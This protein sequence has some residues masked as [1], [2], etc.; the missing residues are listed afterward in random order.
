MDD[1]GLMAQER[2]DDE[3]CHHYRQE[4]QEDEQ[5]GVAEKVDELRDGVI[6]GHGC[7]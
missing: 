6:G 7:Q 3:G 5:V 1:T 2:T 4:G